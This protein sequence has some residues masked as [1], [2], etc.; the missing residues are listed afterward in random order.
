MRPPHRT[1]QQVG[2]LELFYDLVLVACVLALSTAVSSHKGNGTILA[3][4]LVFAGIWWVWLETTLTANRFGGDD[5]GVRRA[6]V[7]V[8]MFLLALVALGAADREHGNASL[9]TLAFAGIFVTLAALQAPTAAGHG[10]LRSFA[11][12]RVAS[13]SACAFLFALAAIPS[14]PLRIACWALAACLAILPAA[15]YRFGGRTGE[16]ELDQP[17]LIERIGLFTLIILGEAFIKVALVAAQGQLHDLD[18]VVMAFVFVLTFGLWWSYFDDIPD[19]RLPRNAGLLRLW[20]ALHFVLHLGIVG[21]VIA[22]AKFLPLAIGKNVPDRTMLLLVVPLALA[23]IALA[24]IGLCSMRR[25]AVPLAV[26]RVVTGLVIS[27]IG[28]IALSVP[29]VSVE[30]TVIAVSGVVLL[31][32]CVEAT[33]RRRTVVAAPESPG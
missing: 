4:I 8:Q 10:S 9:I 19:A 28:V 27:A 12:I 1:H 7:L 16:P 21:A 5:R 31:E 24:G 14:E 23:Y 30:A 11:R 15:L 26:S 20:V 3:T 18:I 33:L 29:F 32:A 22:V 17:H 2:W 13:D 6:I 25:P